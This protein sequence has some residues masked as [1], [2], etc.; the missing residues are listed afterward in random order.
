MLII[1]FF[2]TES[3]GLS[4]ASFDPAEEDDEDVDSKRGAEAA[5]AEAPEE[6]AGN[7]EG[8]EEEAG[9]DEEESNVGADDGDLS[10]SDDGESGGDRVVE[11]FRSLVLN[12]N[13]VEGTILYGFSL[14][15][16]SRTFLIS[17]FG[18]FMDFRTN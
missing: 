18:S 9:N 12:K 4:F 8:P 7:A 3:L 13:E 5:N 2:S 1:Y 11:L 14:I 16:E 17:I 6:E 10:A 15:M